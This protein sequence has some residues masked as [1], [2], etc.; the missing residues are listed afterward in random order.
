MKI[1]TMFSATNYHPWRGYAPQAEWLDAWWLANKMSHAQYNAYSL[2]FR[3]GHA[4]R[5]R[6]LEE[7]LRGERGAFLDGLLL[8]EANAVA[9]AE[10]EKAP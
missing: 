4:K 9:Q 2:K 3:R 5:K 7:V 6:D 1:G 10:P 8:A